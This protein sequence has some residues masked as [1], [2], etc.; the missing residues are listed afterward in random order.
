MS[1]TFKL[2]SGALVAGILM[3]GCGGSS[4]QSSSTTT[5]KADPNATLRFGE[6]NAAADSL[7]PQKSNQSYGADWYG[8]AYES[9]LFATRNRV[10]QPVLA[11]KWTFSSDGLTLDLTL[12]SGVTFS[13]GT[14]FNAAAVKANIERGQTL[15]GSQVKT[16]LEPIASVIAV[17]DTA[18]QLK[19]K[20]PNAAILTDLGGK[21]GYMISPAALNRSDLNVKPVG[22]G[23]F[24]LDSYSPGVSATYTRNP[25]YWG[26]PA[27]VAK[28]QITTF[29][30][31]TAAVN[32]LASG[33][34][35]LAHL[36]DNQA[37]TVVR[38]AKQQV[39]SYPGLG[40]EW[41]GL[42]FGGKF[43]DL[44]VRQ[45]LAYASD[46]KALTDF[47][48]TGS[49]AYQWVTTDSPVFDKS[50][51]N[52]YSYDPQKAKDLL[53]QAGYAS[54]FSFTLIHT[55]RPYTNQSAQVMQAQ[56]AKAGFNVTIQTTDGATILSKCYVQ[57]VCDAISGIY[58]ESPELTRDVADITFANGRRNMGGATALP[59]IA[60][61]LIPATVPANDRTAA[62]Q[63]LQS[64]FVKLIPMVCLRYDVSLYGAR[65]TVFNADVDP[66]ASPVW[67][68]IK[69]AAS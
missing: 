69:M 52:V 41:I 15:T 21:A 50:L 22:T 42:N 10:L 26:T 5:R 35:D 53:A 56:W 19:L 2:L 29:T 44:R 57:H 25:K 4:S 6:T 64:Q 14:P 12:R 23:P 47:A 37:A 40:V 51:G 67:R 9:L 55:D 66:N 27:G 49:P 1:R 39:L 33:Q 31:T 34:I 58:T 7:D 48:G 13:D 38:N 36:F 46:R 3:I 65:N 20:A 18:V 32:A 11:T 16:L 54:G 62:L 59:G 68:S 24:V 8:P 45:A 43:S 28:I 17:N 30:D 63:K 60:D 61:Y